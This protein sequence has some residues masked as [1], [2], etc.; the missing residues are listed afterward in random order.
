MINKNSRFASLLF[1]WILLANVMTAR[2]A[3]HMTLKPCINTLLMKSMN[4]V[5][6]NAHRLALF[7]SI[8]ANGAIFVG[9]IYS[10]QDRGGRNLFMG[11][12][13]NDGFH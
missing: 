13:N 10:G 4:A 9:G 11:W 8:L 6:Q 3:S 5:T 12:S 1:L 2:G 7:H